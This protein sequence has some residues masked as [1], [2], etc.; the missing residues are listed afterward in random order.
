MAESST[1]QVPKKTAE[2]LKDKNYRRQKLTFKQK[3]DTLRKEFG[4]DI[5]I[6]LRQKGKLE[7]YIS[8]DSLI[9]TR[10]PLQLDEIAEYYPTLINTPRCSGV[11][12][13]RE[14]VPHKHNRETGGMERYNYR[15]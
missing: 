2:Q 6:L 13:G 9:N 1:R 7:I 10:W 3:G 15:V 11:A 14:E 12:Q 5:F 4:A 8:R